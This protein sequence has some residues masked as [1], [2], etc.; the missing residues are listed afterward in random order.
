MDPLNS[1]VPNSTPLPPQVPSFQVP[2]AQPV[3]PPILQVPQQ[4]S[5]PSSNNKSPLIFFVAIISIVVV[6]FAG[7][8]L[9][10]NTQGA[11]GVSP[12]TN[13]VVAQP[14]IEVS[15]SPTLVPPN[16]FPTEASASANPFV[17]Q[18]T[19]Q[20]PFDVSPTPSQDY[21]NPFSQ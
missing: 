12:K 6:G 4:P 21:Q 9:F 11:R 5:A 19:Y 17:D 14:T 18:N 10:Q 15:P 8:V 20:N 1:N 2:P 7:I 13:T 16:P 3:I